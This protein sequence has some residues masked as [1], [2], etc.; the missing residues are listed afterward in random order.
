[1]NIIPLTTTKTIVGI[2]LD[3]K[4]LCNVFNNALNKNISFM[5]LGAFISQTTQKSCFD[6]HSCGRFQAG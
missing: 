4:R 1:M 3:N 6:V 5:S 2:V